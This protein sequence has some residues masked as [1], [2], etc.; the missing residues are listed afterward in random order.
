MQGHLV[1]KLIADSARWF[2]RRFSEKIWV[3][4]WNHSSEDSK[5]NLAYSSKNG[6][7]GP[8]V[9]KVPNLHITYLIRYMFQTLPW[10]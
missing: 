9:K 7:I 6:E 3:S 10:T 4:E 2:V 5:K 1:Y 8:S